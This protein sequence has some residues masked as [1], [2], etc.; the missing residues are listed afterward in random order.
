MRGF[1]TRTGEFIS[2]ESSPVPSRRSTPYK[3]KFKSTEFV[4]DHDSD[5]EDRA[6]CASNMAFMSLLADPKV[7]RFITVLGQIA[8]AEGKSPT[9]GLEE[10]LGTVRF[11]SDDSMILP[12]LL[13]CLLYKHPQMH[14]SPTVFY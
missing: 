7:Q 4:E 14:V 10:S 12:E 6:P 9:P 3:G 8:C 2:G 11:G 1:H 13:S 5:G